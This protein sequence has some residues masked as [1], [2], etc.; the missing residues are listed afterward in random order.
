MA[1]FK[2]EEIEQLK[3]GVEQRNT[4]ETHNQQTLTKSLICESESLVCSEVFVRNEY[5]KAFRV[6]L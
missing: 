1:C 5:E 2:N 4:H 3:R 6:N